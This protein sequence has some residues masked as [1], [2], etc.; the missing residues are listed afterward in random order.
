ELLYT[1]F[2]NAEEHFSI[3]KIKI[4]ETNEDYKEK[5][6]VGKGYFAHLQEGVTYSF[7]GH[8]ENHPKFG[9]QYH[10]NTYQTYIPKTRDGLIT[11][12]S[13]DLFYGVG[14]KTA[15]R[16]IDTLGEQAIS[17]ILNKP[18]IISTIPGLAR[19]TGE[20]LIKT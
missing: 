2:Q 9:L 12:L 14:K 8:F 7:Y 16:I 18:E 5:E 6:I 20:Q 15:T 3:A 19:K 17:K 1:I 13:S 4:I 11:Y 10:V